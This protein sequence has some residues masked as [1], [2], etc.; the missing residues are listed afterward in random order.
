MKR[1]FLLFAVCG[2]LFSCAS[3]NDTPQNNECNA[4]ESCQKEQRTGPKVRP[5]AGVGVGIGSGGF[6]GVGGGVGLRI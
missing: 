6:R 2:F 4:Q 5:T 1:M 3:S